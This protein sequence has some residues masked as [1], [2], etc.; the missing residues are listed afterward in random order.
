L[1]NWPSWLAGIFELSYEPLPQ[2]A[3]D[4]PEKT[5]VVRHQREVGPLD[6]S[7]SL[8][9]PIDAGNLELVLVGQ[10]LHHR[11]QIEIRVRDIA[12]NDP[13]GLEMLL[14]RRECFG[15]QQMRWHRV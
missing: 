12:D 6:Q 9:R 13:I 5:L 14:I 3:H 8:G 11:P 15:R 1:R 4:W 2:A 7:R 10:P